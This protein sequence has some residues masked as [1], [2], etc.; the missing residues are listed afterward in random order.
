MMPER[1]FEDFKLGL[2]LPLAEY[3]VTRKEILAFADEFGQPPEAAATA[4]ASAPDDEPLC[5]S[6]WHCCAMFMRMMFDGWLGASS[7]MGSPGVKQ[8]R[9]VKPVRAYD[10]LSGT[11][12]VLEA[13]A[14]RS[15]PQMGLVRFRHEVRNQAGDLAM[16]MDNTIMFARRVAA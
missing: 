8:L 6:G 12:I 5:A 9:W 16:W 11:S 13:R 10:L 4:G 7:S 14:S 3:R 1:Y 2:E 15:R